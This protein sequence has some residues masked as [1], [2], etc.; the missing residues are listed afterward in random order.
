MIVVAGN[1]TLDDTVLPD[2]RTRMGAVGG[3]VFYSGLG[4]A[5]WDQPVGLFSRI[6]DDFPREHLEALGVAGL[7]TSGLRPHAGPT[8][9]NWVIY[10]WDGRRH[11]IFRTAP[12]RFPA[13]SPEPPELPARYAAAAA[14]YH[15]AA[16]PLDHAE[17]LVRQAAALPMRPLVT[18]DT[19][20]DFVAGYQDRLTALLPLLAAFLPSREEVGLWFGDDDPWRHIGDLLALGPGAV[21]I[22]LGAEGALVQDRAM[23]KP[24]LMAAAPAAVVDVT[25]AG[26]AFCGGF[27]AQLAATHDVVAAARAGA[28]AASFAIE[29]YGSLGLL[30]VTPDARSRRL[31]ALPHWKEM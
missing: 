16:L 3:D 29:G 8:I 4:A 13:L 18:L 23:A 27:A 14:A 20:E 1:V 21:A 17:R 12:E 9:R 31:A 28:V 26:D 24:V 6:G 19:H 11:F 5:L 15:V 22:K 30:N 2:G 10:E 7:D 25:G